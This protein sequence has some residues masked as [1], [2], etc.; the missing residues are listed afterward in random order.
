MDFLYNTHKE[1]LILLVK[2]K[3]DFMIIGG[4]SVI[5]YGYNRGTGDLDLWLKPDNENKI[6]VLKALRK[7][8]IKSVDLNKLEKIDF[9]DTNVFFIGEAPEKIDF[10]TKVQNVAWDEAINK[11]QYLP[12]ENIRV[13]VV[14]Y[15]EL[16]LMKLAS[17][18]LKDKADVEELQKI[19]KFRE[20]N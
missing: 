19:R 16:V 18:R 20:I 2:N 10:L 17:D 6:K 5:Y 1:L 9:T 13:P 15:N 3:V 4:Y 11:V 12:F 14:G 7:F 8:G